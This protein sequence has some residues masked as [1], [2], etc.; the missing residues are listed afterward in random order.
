MLTTNAPFELGETLKGTDD[1]GNLINA[2]K[3]GMK[4]MLPYNDLTGPTPAKRKTGMPIYAIILRNLSGATLYGKRLASLKKTAGFN[5]VEAVDGYNITLYQT[6]CIAIDPYLVTGGVAANDLFWG[7]FS[8]PTILTSPLAGADFKALNIA[9]GDNLV[10]ATGITTGAITSGMVAGVSIAN[11]TDAG[12]AL[13]AAMGRIGY[14][15]S[16]LTSGQTNADLLVD[17]AVQF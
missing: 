13:S 6:P 1:N 11:A 10:A 5:L 3:L 9:V 8:G 17:M 2:A 16:A 7:I 15:L 14:A 12:G 4:Y